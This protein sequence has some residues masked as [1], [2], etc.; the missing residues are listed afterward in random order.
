MR[1]FLNDIITSINTL[2]KFI[3]NIILSK[4]QL[5]YMGCVCMANNKSKSDIQLFSIFKTQEETCNDLMQLFA[6]FQISHFKFTQDNEFATV[7]RNG[8]SS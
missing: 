4:E 5:L 1:S 2:P 3:S 6:A 8:K 7:E